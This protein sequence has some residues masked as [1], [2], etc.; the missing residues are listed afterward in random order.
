MTTVVFTYSCGTARVS[1]AG[2]NVHARDARARYHFW[3]GRVGRL[4]L[5]GFSLYAS[6]PR[7]RSETIVLT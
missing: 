5:I 6:D 2:R 7:V 4:R 3:V 1:P